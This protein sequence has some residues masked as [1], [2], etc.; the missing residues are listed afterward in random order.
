ML[1]PRCGY[2]AEKE[3]TVCP[4][5]GE[6]LTTGTDA[7]YSGAEAI[8]QGKRARQAIHEAAERTMEIK[9]RRR[10]G[11]SRATVEMPALKDEREDEEN[12]P[13]YRISESEIAGEEGGEEVVFERRRRTVYDENDDIREQARAYTEWIEQGGG[14]RLKMVNWMKIA[15]AGVVLLAMIIGGSWLFLKKTEGGQKVM[16][17]LGRE[18]TSAALWSVGEDLMDNGDID[19]AIESFEKAM[20]QDELEKH[21]DVD[22]MLML[23]SAYEA[24]GRTED[25]AKL[26]EYIYEGT[27]SRPEAYINRIRILLNDG[28]LA[29]AGDLMKKAYDNTG[30][31]T[32]QTQRRDLLPEVPVVDPVGGFKEKKVLLTLYS[33]QGYD[34]YYTFE[35][36]EHAKLPQDGILFTEKK[37]LDEGTWNLRAVAVNGELVS[38]EIKGTYKIIMPSPQM[39][40]VGL[41]PGAYKT[42]KKVSLRPGK[43]NE[44]DDDIRIYYTVDG[45]TPNEDS[46]EY[47]GE[48]VL[49]PTGHKVTIK[50]IAVNQYGKESQVQEVSYKIEVKPYP[51]TAWDI[52]EKVSGLDLNKTTMQAFQAEYGQG[53]EVEIETPKN[54]GFTTALRKFEYPWGYAVMNLNKKTWVLVELRFNDK[55]TFKAPRDT[56]VGDPKDYV[57]GKFRDMGQVASAS[58]NRG[59]YHLDNL[60]DGKYLA[61]ENS[62]RYRIRVDGTWH[63]LKYYLNDN[64]TVK[65]IEYRYIPK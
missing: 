7:P 60:S 58:G 18:A 31:S 53:Q 8:R 63:Q 20:L 54:S 41:A 39:P 65:E 51:L 11:A 25:A 12:F 2:Y 29:A 26:Y 43:D 40:Q 44:K 32:F 38:D 46:P 45:S 56:G 61:K 42:R 1:C 16:A 59:L 22:G 5:C 48:P 33:T 19:G 15:I 55:S 34:V 13:D 10:S 4:E 62:I 28:K 9:R 47:T 49:L 35:D 21:V 24:A 14:K 23:G 57:I 64:G 50:A 3:E 52:E 17:R 27:P 37:L 6:I 36:E 30:E